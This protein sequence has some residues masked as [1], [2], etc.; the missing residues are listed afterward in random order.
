MRSM[1]TQIWPQFANEP[2]AA[3]STARSR[4]AS[5]RTIIGSLPPSS[6]VTGRSSSPA[7]T[8]MRRP[9]ALEPVK[10]IFDTPRC[11]DERGARVTRAVHDAHEP[12]GAPASANSRATHSPQS[13]VSSDGLSTTALPAATA[14]TVCERGMLSGKFHGEMTPITPSGS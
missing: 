4:S 6:S 13:G 3:P 14:V 7:A 9:V 8:A 10:T 11:G 1:P 2:H 5:C 12:G